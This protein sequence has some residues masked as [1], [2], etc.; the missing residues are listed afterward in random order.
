M[1]VQIDEVRKK[2]K[3][4][5]ANFHKGYFDGY[6]NPKRCREEIDNFLKKGIT[7]LSENAQDCFNGKTSG[8]EDRIKNS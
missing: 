4:K 7:D 2:F 3:D 8:V 5:K 1:F 6:N